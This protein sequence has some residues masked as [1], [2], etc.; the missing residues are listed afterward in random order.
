MDIDSDLD[1]GR[2]ETI[3]QTEKKKL[4]G[5]PR[6]RRRRR[7][8]RGTVAVRIRR[9]RCTA[10]RGGSRYRG[11]RNS[12]RAA[13]WPIVVKNRGRSSANRHPIDDGQ[14][15]ASRFKG[16]SEMEFLRLRPSVSDPVAPKHPTGYHSVTRPEGNVAKERLAKLK[17]RSFHFFS[18]GPSYQTGYDSVTSNVT[19][20][21]RPGMK[22]RR[23]SEQGKENTADTDIE[24]A[25]R[26]RGG[27]Q[28]VGATAA[29][30]APAPSRWKR[31]RRGARV[32]WQPIGAGVRLLPRL[33]AFLRQTAKTISQ[34]SCT[35][36][37]IQKKRE[38]GRRL[39]LPDDA[40]ASDFQNFFPGVMA[41][42]GWVLGRNMFS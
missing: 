7:R 13:R 36:S 41:V 28:T 24:L 40:I 21:G 18:V 33:L 8:S 35:C 14:L 31:T 2:V 27:V 1:C 20:R 22:T 6:R 16:R 39:L 37:S 38:K 42:D 19:E 3:L 25:I 29:A 23:K 11:G 30:S 12:I 10:T 34:V 26:L 4:T 5:W 15:D 9:T 32:Q 17:Q